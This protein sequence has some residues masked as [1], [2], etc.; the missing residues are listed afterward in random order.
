MKR[1][2]LASGSNEAERGPDGRFRP[3]NRAGV[4]RGNP[5]AR[6]VAE[7]R[8]AVLCSVT[9]AELAK[10]FRAMYRAALGGDTAAAK[11]LSTWTLGQPIPQDVAAELD[12]LQARIEE[13]ECR[14]GPY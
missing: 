2:P 7:L 11:V 5:H 8:A 6:R 10:V 3:G 14:S 13:L 1:P 9:P 12:A 4:G